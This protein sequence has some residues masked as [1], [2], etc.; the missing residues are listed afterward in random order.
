MTQNITGSPTPGSRATAPTD[1]GVH[2][3]A[4]RL[5]HAADRL[6]DVLRVHERSPRRAVAR[7]IRAVVAGHNVEAGRDPRN[8]E[9]GP[10]NRHKATA[11]LPLYG[12]TVLAATAFEACWD[13][14]GLGETRI[15]SEFS[16]K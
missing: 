9:G 12:T 6:A 2:R 10:H 16:S 1:L 4:R 7:H 5:E 13:V 14:L 11:D 8:A 3:L 15:R